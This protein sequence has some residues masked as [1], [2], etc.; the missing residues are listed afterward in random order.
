MR[1]HTIASGALWLMCASPAFAAERCS[2]LRMADWLVGAWIA[3]HDERTHVE[4]W[5]R[6]SDKTFEGTGTTTKGQPPVMIDSETL[7]LVEMDAGVFYVA[8]VRH[9]P[10]PI[11]FE[12][13]ECSAQRLVFANPAHDFPRRLDYSFDA[14]SGA[15]T[16]HVSDGGA[17]GFTLNFKR[18]PEKTN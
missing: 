18:Q 6:V 12:L 7:R 3:E 15:L 2:S 1:L 16:V 11:A 14:S 8:K 17:K 9:N 10:L 13:I 5:T 4:S